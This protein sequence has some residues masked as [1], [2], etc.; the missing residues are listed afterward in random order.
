MR[1]VPPDNAWLY[2]WVQQ[3]ASSNSL[4]LELTNIVTLGRRQMASSRTSCKNESQTWPFP[5]ISLDPHE[6]ALLVRQAD[7]SLLVEANVH[8]VLRKS[9]S[10]SMQPH[11][12]KRSTHFSLSTLGSSMIDSVRKSARKQ[13]CTNAVNHTLT[14]WGP[15]NSLSPTRQCKPRS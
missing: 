4:A 12:R 9:A 6:I 11:H 15:L 5:G 14:L 13:K 10:V 8:Q 3:L 7:L 2:A 1:T